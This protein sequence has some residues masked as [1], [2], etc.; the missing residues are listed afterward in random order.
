M[1]R[2]SHTDSGN[3]LKSLFKAVDVL[4]CF[5]QVDRA[6]T[7]AEIA[8]RAG[9]PKTTAHRI[10]ATFREAGF[11]EQDHGRDSYRLGLRLF[12]L[13]N[14]VLANMDLHREA[15]PFIEQLM[16][17]SGEGVHL[18]VF[19]GTRVV[20]VDHRDANGRI[21]NTVT[22]ITGAPAYCTGVGKAALAFQEPAVVARVIRDVL[23]PF[24]QN[25]ITD[26]D[27]LRRELAVVRERGYAI[28]NGEHEP[29]LH[30][31][32]API[33]NAAG[34]VFGAISVSGPAIRLT[35]DRDEALGELVVDVA[36][37]LSRQLGCRGDIA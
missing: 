13:G 22:T 19:T 36:A 8:E 34:V 23:R 21:V 26:A 29:G 9:I 2:T 17:R 15:T 16:E 3:T 10:L 6:L 14:L 24:T 7:L 12:E 30:C 4:D 33:R 20:A 27:V 31:V 28:D 11:V 37:R 5:S 18:F 1:A 32:A 25:T 35:E